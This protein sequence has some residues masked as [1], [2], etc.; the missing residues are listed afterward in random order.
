[1]AM[2]IA[3]LT[4][5]ELYA[6][7]ATQPDLWER[8]FYYWFSV[9]LLKPAARSGLTPDD[10]TAVSLVTGVTAALLL[11]PRFG[12]WLNL[13]GVLL[14]N[15]SNVCD[16]LDGQL[17]RV[18]NLYSPLGWLWDVIVDQVKILAVTCALIF[19]S[20]SQFTVMLGWMFLVVL[21][22]KH[23]FHFYLEHHAPAKVWNFTPE[24]E[25]GEKA[26]L[27]HDACVLVDRVLYRAK[28]GLLT[29]G[30]FYLII[31]LAVLLTV[32]DLA[33]ILLLLYALC[34]LVFTIARHAT[35]IAWLQ[36]RLS[37][38]RLQ[39]AS[40]Y[41]FGAGSAGKAVLFRL[42]RAGLD[43]KLFLDN[44]PALSGTQVEGVPVVLPS[45]LKADLP[46]DRVI[47]IA[48]LARYDIERQ[49]REAGFPAAN[50]LHV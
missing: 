8:R 3:Q 18:R 48:S 24:A 16:A 9:R 47:L 20:E 27:L 32:P 42:R 19:T 35:R 41:I 4:P 39:G 37:Q 50:L 1:M 5:R 25:A 7:F 28:L 23:F 17:A 30:E 15:F 10:I 26:E 13:L 44:N 49:L 33:I 29:V 43:A 45:E 21:A 14:L 34:G 38:L 46:A 31:S 40:F 6:R 2:D 12:W 36:P 22:L 11:F